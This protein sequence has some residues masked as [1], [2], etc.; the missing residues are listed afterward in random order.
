MQQSKNEK[1][2][3]NNREPMDPGRPFPEPEVKPAITSPT[4]VD[5]QSAA[6]DASSGST[7]ST[8]N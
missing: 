5:S 7:G 8:G 2:A 3:N 4:P 1:Q 6:S